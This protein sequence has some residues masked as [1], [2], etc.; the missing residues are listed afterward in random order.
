MSKTRM[1][2]GAFAIGFA[3]ACSPG[4]FSDPCETDDC[5][6]A[7]TIEPDCGPEICDGV[8]NDCDGYIDDVDADGDGH[9]SRECR[10]NDSPLPTDDC[11][12]SNDKV[13]PSLPE[14]PDNLDNDCDGEIDEDT[15]SSDDD[16][17]CYC[18]I[19]PCRGSANVTCETV[20]G[21]DCDDNNASVNPGAIDLPEHVGSLD[22][23]CDGIDGT[24]DDMVFVDPLT[25]LD[26]REGGIDAPVRTLFRGLQIAQTLKRSWVALSVGEVSGQPLEGIHLAGGYDAGENWAR[27]PETQTQMVRS[28]VLRNWTEPTIW[29]RIDLSSA[30]AYDAGSSIPL[31]VDGVASLTLQGCNLHAG[32][33]ATGLGG[34]AVLD[35]ENGD[36]GEPGDDG[37]CGDACMGFRDGGLGAI[38]THDG[39]GG[40]GGFVIT[41]DDPRDGTAG[42]GV[43][44]GTG[45][46]SGANGGNGGN[47][48]PGLAGVGGAALG[49]FDAASARYLPANGTNGNAGSPGSGGGGGAGGMGSFPLLADCNAAFGGAGGG[50]GSGGHGASGGNAGLGGG[51][52]VGMVLT[53]GSTAFLEDCSITTSGGGTGGRGGLGGLGGRGGLGGLGGAGVLL[54]VTTAAGGRGGDGGLG[55]N[56]GD[57]GGGGGGPSIGVVCRDSVVTITGIHTQL[58]PG[59]LG[60]VPSGASGYV[61]GTEGCP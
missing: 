36:P 56:G 34:L 8:D 4:V 14:I 11:D 25:G 35:A 15:V 13:S 55:G 1:H 26:E 10:S 48:D 37:C 30:D 46:T 12:D 9:V 20:E 5:Q 44:G 45:G 28:V 50:G 58:G 43:L 31:W 59:G 60:G 54:P 2:W 57:G 22:Q 38:S 19:A 6:T 61:G 33:G 3:M 41:A 32:L 49:L 17:D 27:P 7:P 53:G 16:G 51:A 52:S 24:I 40:D 29:Q 18:E 47:G 21:G 42:G 23:N 39:S